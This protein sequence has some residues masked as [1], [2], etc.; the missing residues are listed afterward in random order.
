[1]FIGCIEWPAVDGADVVVFTD[2]SVPRL[3]RVCAEYLASQVPAEDADD[4]PDLDL[5]DSNSVKDWLS[6]SNEVD[7]FGFLTIHKP[8]KPGTRANWIPL[9][10]VQGDEYLTYEELIARN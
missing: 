7:N 10:G 1:M 6:I 2:E 8:G 4:F 3:M 5:E 9:V